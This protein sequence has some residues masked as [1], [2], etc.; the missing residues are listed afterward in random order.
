MKCQF[1]SKCPIPNGYQFPVYNC[2]HKGINQKLCILYDENVNKELYAVCEKCV[3]IQPLLD[4]IPSDQT[5]KTK[6]DL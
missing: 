2:Y 6:A 1:R 5:H 4:H 3:F